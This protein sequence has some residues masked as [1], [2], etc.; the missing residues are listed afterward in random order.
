M[1]TRLY[2]APFSAAPVSAA[3]SAEWDVTSGAFRRAL[4]TLRGEDEDEYLQL[5]NNIGPAV[6]QDV[7]FFQHIS[8]PI[9]PGPIGGTMLG[10]FFALAG[11]AGHNLRA[12]ILAKV[13]SNDGSTLRGVLYAGDL[14][15]L[16]GDPSQEWDASQFYNYQFPRSTAATLSTVTALAND[17]V[18]V[19]VGYRQHSTG[20]TYAYMALASG[21][22]TGDV[23][24]AGDKFDSPT[25]YPYTRATWV[26]F[27]DNLFTAR[28]LP[29]VRA[30]ILE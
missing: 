27:S 30:F 5:T 24:S 16:T 17:R 15:T 25:G 13:M 20:L 4:S 2:A 22:V 18:V 9:A 29:F 8:D 6:N 1:T 21:V 14:A 11:D 10:E 19:E 12:Q 26:E 28:A 7:L 3:F 23:T